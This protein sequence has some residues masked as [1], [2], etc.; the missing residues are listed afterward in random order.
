MRKRYEENPLTKQPGGATL[1]FTFND[2]PTEVRRN[3]KVPKRYVETV[4]DT[5]VTENSVSSLVSVYNKSDDRYEYVR[6]QPD[7]DSQ[8]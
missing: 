5:L 7:V 4:L 2:R 8:L 6:Q 3:V 1:V